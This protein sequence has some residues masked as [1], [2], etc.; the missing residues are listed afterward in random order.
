MTMHKEKRKIMSKFFQLI[1]KILNVNQKRRTVLV[2]FDVACFVL[3]DIFFFFIALRASGSVPVEKMDIFLL[4]SGVQLLAIFSMRQIFGIYRNVWRYSNTKAYY[5]LVLADALGSI[6]ALLSIRLLNW[7][8]PGVYY[9]LWQA[10]TVGSLVALVTLMSRFAYSLLHK[11]LAKNR[12]TKCGRLLRLWVLAAWVLTWWGICATI[13]ILDM[14]LYSSWILMKLK[15]VIRCPVC[16][17]I[18]RSKRKS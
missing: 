10:A 1:N 7:L 15:S 6:V 14:N 17:C 16:M 3:V 5:H 18:I 9:G 13:P 8:I 11:G 12:E 4:N 2:A